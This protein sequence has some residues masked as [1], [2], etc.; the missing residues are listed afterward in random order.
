MSIID[1][2]NIIEKI[3]SNQ[4][5]AQVEYPRERK[6]DYDFITDVTKSVL[7]NRQQVDKHNAK[8]DESFKAYRNSSNAGYQAFKSDCIA[9]IKDEL[10][11]FK[12]SDSVFDIVYSAGYDSGH[13]DG[14][15]GI[16]YSCRD[17]ILLLQDV[18]EVM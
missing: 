13:S 11:S 7:W 15:F 5:S 6:R 16:L 3:N 4:Y 17:I 12:L 2:S 14:F 1:I 8:V 10:S 18:F 9:Y